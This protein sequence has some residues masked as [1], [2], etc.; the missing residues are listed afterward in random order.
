M[1]VNR[2][3]KDAV[4]VFIEMKRL[5]YQCLKYISTNF[6]LVHSNCLVLLGFCFFVFCLSGCLFFVCFIVFLLCFFVY[7]FLCMFELFICCIQSILIG[8]LYL[9]T[10]K[11]PSASAFV[12]TFLTIIIANLPFLSTVFF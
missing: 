4:A 11:C 10:P 5:Q 12:L 9:S 7:L 3:I 8:F 2:V 1:S 6:E